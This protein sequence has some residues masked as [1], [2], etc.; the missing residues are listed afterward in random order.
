[1]KHADKET[2]MN[3]KALSLIIIFIALAVSLNVYGPKIPYPFA[4]FLYF[5]LWEIPIVVAFLL[6]GLKSGIFVSVINTLILFFV[7]PGDLPTGPIYNFVAI[8]SMML[9]VYL[10][11]LVA[12][13][14]CKTQNF[15]EYLRSHIALFTISALVLGAIMRV[16]FMTVV[17]YFALQQTYPL[18]FALQEPAVLAFLPL[19]GLFNAI[20]A[21]YTIPIAVG[22]T[23]AVMSRVKMQ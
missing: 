23:V 1:M 18:G 12:K 3:A 8:I 22:I 7:F 9:G 21:I 16:V 6:I 4:P 20:V 19:G 2:S 13:H 15:G 14:G 11:Y 10:P 5:Q 17:N